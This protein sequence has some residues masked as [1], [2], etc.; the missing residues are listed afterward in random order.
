MLPQSDLPYPKGISTIDTSNREMQRVTTYLEAHPGDGRQMEPFCAVAQLEKGELKEVE[1]CDVDS[2]TLIRGDT[3]EDDESED[4]G[5]PIRKDG[6][7]DPSNDDRTARTS[8]AGGAQRKLQPRLGKSVAPSGAWT[9]RA[10]G[11]KGI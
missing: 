4:G 2:R 9:L 8:G 1:G 3:K 10:R 6:P 11:R 7:A 5:G